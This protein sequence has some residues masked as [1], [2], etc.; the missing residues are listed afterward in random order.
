MESVEAFQEEVE[1]GAHD[2]WQT[3]LDSVYK[4]IAGEG[5]QMTYAK[6][7]VLEHYTKDLTEKERAKYEAAKALLGDEE[8]M[9]EAEDDVIAEARRQVG[10]IEDEA[11]DRFATDLSRGAI[12]QSLIEDNGLMGLSPQVQ[13]QMAAKIEDA[14]RHME[15]MKQQD[16][17]IKKNAQ[18]KAGWSSDPVKLNKIVTQQ[19]RG[20]L[21]VKP[22]N[23]YNLRINEDPNFLRGTSTTIELTGKELNSLNTAM[24][25]A[26]DWQMSLFGKEDGTPGTYDG[27]TVT[28]M[29]SYPYTVKASLITDP[30][31][32]SPEQYD[33]SLYKVEKD[34]KTYYM[35]AGSGQD[36]TIDKV[37]KRRE[38]AQTTDI[39]ND[40]YE[41]YYR[42]GVEEQYKRIEDNTTYTNFGIV[43][44]KIGNELVDVNTSDIMKDIDNMF[45]GKRSSDGN[46]KVSNISG[47]L[48]NSNIS[49]TPIGDNRDGIDINKLVERFQEEDSEITKKDIYISQPTIEVATG[50][51]GDGTK[52]AVYLNYNI[53]T[54]NTNKHNGIYSI[55]LSQ[56]SGAEG[57]TNVGNSSTVIATAMMTKT[58]MDSNIL[59]PIT[60]QPFATKVKNGY[61]VSVGGTEKTYSEAEFRGLYQDRITKAQ[62]LGT[63]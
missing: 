17:N 56:V 32:K 28:Q 1:H 36:E 46:K 27:W 59:D 58:P 40:N 3:E 29:D 6:E 50:V 11:Q 55:D 14:K 10:V 51:N 45:L 39:T 42:K 37:L 13:L 4:G 35:H 8:A 41:E 5:G 2:K 44:T 22:N 7:I 24:R 21:G 20:E 18:F 15:Y 23:K 53:H 52:P 62:Q 9:D 48:I 38:V 19:N 47:Q 25:R 30:N 33:G 57:L 31:A 60:H 49:L 12:P 34:G 54:N 16:A 63:L 43:S 26:G 61:V